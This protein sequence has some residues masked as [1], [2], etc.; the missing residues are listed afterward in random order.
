[1][2]YLDRLK[3]INAPSS[4]LTEP[5]KAAVNNQKCPD[6]V[7]TKPTKSGFDGFVSRPSWHFQNF[8][9]RI[10][11]EEALVE[12]TAIMEHDGNLPRSQ[13]VRLAVLATAYYAHHWSC[14]TCLSGTSTG[15]RVHRPC[16]E[17]ARLWRVYSEAASHKK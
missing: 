11:I 14:P 13:A 6:T 4:D 9:A 7:P 5:T 3:S 2:D 12:R 8:S 15:S 10:A 16:P 1:M 17:E